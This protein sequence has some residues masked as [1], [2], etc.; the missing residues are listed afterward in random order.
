MA[1]IKVAVIGGGPAGMFFCHH[2][3]KIQNSHT[4][5][6]EKKDND[7]GNVGSN[8]VQVTC[9][10]KDLTPGGVWKTKEQVL[11]VSSK[12]VDDEGERIS[13]VIYDELWTNGPSH[14]LEMHD[15]TFDEHFNSSEPIPMYLPRKDVT[16]YLMGRVTK[17][18]PTFFQDY[19]Q[20]GTKVTSVVPK[21]E[22]FGFDVTFEDLQSGERKEQHFDKVIWAAGENGRVKI[23]RELLDLFE[24]A[25]VSEE[26]AARV[27]LHSS[28]TRELKK[29]IEEKRSQEEESR[30]LLIGGSYSAEDIALQCLK[31]GADHVEVTCRSADDHICSTDDWPGERVTVHSSS[32]V[33][34]V[35]RSNQGIFDVELEPVVMDW[36][37]GYKTEVEHEAEAENRV[38]IRNVDAVV[39]TTGYS[40]HFDMLD[41]SLRPAANMLPTGLAIRHEEFLAS[42]HDCAPDWLPENWKMK[43]DRHAHAW[44]G[45]VPAGLGKTYRVKTTHPDLQCGFFLKNIDMMY[46][47]ENDFETPLVGLDVFAWILAAT[48]TGEVAMPSVEKLHEMNTQELRDAMDSPIA[49]YFMDE[50]YAAVIDKLPAGEGQFWPSRND[51]DD[52]T[53]ECTFWDM[54]G[55]YEE[56]N[57]RLLAEYMHMS[58]Y[59]GLSLGSRK[60]LNRNGKLMMKFNEEC[61]KAREDTWKEIKA[62]RSREDWHTFRDNTKNCK[63]IRSLYTNT[64]ARPLKKRWL[65]AVGGNCSVKN[66]DL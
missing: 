25:I 12:G 24:D 10:E 59:P 17:N 62:D 6:E 61:I 51:D 64:K 8:L 58:K 18:N 54:W 38:W 50:G 16:E 32:R 3:H 55:D 39:F 21:G 37:A 45:D 11:G 65:D 60:G 20:F 22:A 34:S 53:E 23:P 9:F 41:E 47:Y 42:E 57:M 56:S 27:L 2:I 66:G 48:L 35:S 40:S 26:T 33:K 52:E 28:Q 36:H 5:E 7:S 63:K 31:W 4:T 19:F 46:L 43:V 49:R 1:P 13:T 14:C 44:T 30:I 15:Y 29:I